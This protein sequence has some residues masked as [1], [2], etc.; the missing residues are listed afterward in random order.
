MISFGRA[1]LSFAMG[2]GKKEMQR[3]ARGHPQVIMMNWKLKFD[4]R[5]PGSSN[6]DSF[7]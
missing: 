6:T 1:S 7:R 5:Y 3:V 4:V 2:S